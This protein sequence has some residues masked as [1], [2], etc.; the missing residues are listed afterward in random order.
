M[1]PTEAEPERLRLEKNEVKRKKKKD[2]NVKKETTYL[3]K[4][5]LERTRHDERVGDPHDDAWRTKRRG[6]PKG[7]VVD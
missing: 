3:G 4:S 1:D 5:L 6:F 7:T 2:N